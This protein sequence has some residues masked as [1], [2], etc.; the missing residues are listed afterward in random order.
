MLHA[1]IMAGGSGTRFWPR[2][3]LSLP[4]QFLRFGG[5]RSLIQLTFDRLA[6][7]VPPERVWV[8]T[9]AN[10]VAST[11]EHLPEL[12]ADNIVGEPCGRD[13][14]PCIALAALLMSQRDPHA[15]MAVLPA[16]HLIEP[17]AKFQ[18]AILAADG[19]LKQQPQS[20]VTF[21]I[22]PNYPATGYGYLSREAQ[23]TVVHVEGVPIHQ[24]Q[25]FHEKPKLELAQEF[26]QTGTYYWNSGIFAWRADA[27]LAEIERH[28]APIVAA[29]KAI[30][31]AWSTPNRAAT[32]AAEYPKAT[33][34]SIDYAV[35]EKAHNVAMIEAPFAWDD[36]GSWLA[37]E[38]VHPPDA[39]GNVVLG[40]HEGLDTRNCVIAGE[41]EHLVTTLGVENLIVVQTPDATLVADRRHEQSVKQLLNQLK[42][43]GLERYL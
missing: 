20:L 30:A 42:V 13:T 26:I 27:I 39:T 16:D 40:R 8:V 5:E 18:Q 29:T 15:S 38:R 34:I 2:S 33:K 17:A 7:L 3:R 37:L 25:S 1:V 28:A 43:R 35:M 14:A 12:P 9:N 32:F 31:L 19:F 36:V 10:Y 22:T 23:A 11:L 41:P 21:G 6:G 24:L 4:K